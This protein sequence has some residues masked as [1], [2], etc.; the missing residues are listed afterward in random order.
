MNLKIDSLV[1]KI[2]FGYLILNA[3]LLVAVTLTIININEVEET[4]DEL[5]NVRHPTSTAEVEMVNGINHSVACLRGW[6]LLEKP[7]FKEELDEIWENEIRAPLNTLITLSDSWKLERNRKQLNQLITLVDKLELYQE[8][9]INLEIEEKKNVAQIIEDRILPIINKIRTL[10]EQLT[11]DHEKITSEVMNAVS[12]QIDFLSFTERILLISGLVIGLF[13]AFYITRSSTKPIHNAVEV[14]ENIAKGKIDTEVNVSG[15]KEVNQLGAALRSLRQSLLINKRETEEH[16]WLSDGENKLNEAI[17]GDQSTH[18]LADAFMK[19][20]ARYLNANIG[21]V[22]IIDQN[23]KELI[24]NASFAL[25]VDENLKRIKIGE[26]IIGHVAKE[27]NI[28]YLNELDEKDIRLESS[29]VKSTPKNIAVIPFMFEDQIL[30]VF[31]IG[32]KQEFKPIEREFITICQET[33]GIAM[34]SAIAKEEINLLYE[35]TKEKT[36]QLEN[37]K[38]EI[39][40]Q[41]EGLNNVALVSITDPNGD[42]TY[43]NDRFLEV[44]KF[45]REE[46]IGKNHRILKSGKQSDNLF[47]GMWKAISMGRVWNGEI[48]NKAKDGSYYWVDTTIIPILNLDNEV[49]KYLSV[50]FEITKIKEQQE[51]LKVLNEE[52]EEQSQSL[53]EQQEELQASNEELEE[54]SQNLKQQQE[55]LEAS[56]EELE[57]QAQV[58]E[59]KN[60]DLEAARTAIELKAEQLEVSSKYKSEFLANM[61]HELRTPLNSL[62]I[63]SKDLTDNKNGNLDEEQIESASIINK[64]GND[65][66]ELINEILDLSKVEAGKM[67]LN[68]SDIGIKDIAENINRNFKK[69]AEEK[70]IGWE[71]EIDETIPKTFRSDQQRLEQII[72]NLVSNAIKFTEEGKV[73]VLFNRKG[74]DQLSICV[75]DT[76]IGIPEDKLDAIFEAFQQADGSTSRKFGGT[77][78]GL[79]IS[80]E[81]TKLLGGTIIVES[82]Y[83]KGSAFT[84]TIP[85]SPEENDN[86]PKP[87]K[88]VAAKAERKSKI[89]NEID[90]DSE[91]INYPTI[92]D[93]REEVNPNDRVILIIEDDLNFSKIVAQQATKKDFK[94]ITAA[95]GE[96]GLMLAQ[97]YTPDAIILDIDLPGIDG[98]TVLQELKNDPD[99]RHIP[100]HIISGKDKN[101]ETIR[102]GAIEF[103]NKPV[104]KKELD[105]AF[106]NIQEFI[107]RQMKNLLIVEDNENMRNTIVKLIGNGDVKCHVASS[108][109]EALQKLKE[110]HVDCIVLDLGLPDMSGQEMLKQ[111][112][113]QSEKNKKIPPVIIYTGKELTKEED[114]ELQQ[115]AETIIVKGVKSEERLLDE[116]ALFLHRTVKNLPEN[117]QKMITELYDKETLFQHKTVLVV[118]D[119]MRN[120]FAL[121]KVLQ[122]KGMEVIKADNGIT[123]LKAL[124]ENDNIDIVL[125]DIMMPKMDGYTC[126]KEIRAQQQYINLPI[127][128]ITAKAMKEDKQKCIDAG[129]NDY[130]PKPVDIERLFSL[131]RIWIKK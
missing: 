80:R 61:S 65:L 115:F 15:F 85:L 106:E 98:Y 92:E 75:E 66:L 96:D 52:L 7:K 79:S 18:A 32:K 120:V 19:F 129:A 43:V 84:L 1:K 111:L 38:K 30:G 117:K 82:E 25:Q 36:Y 4:T 118:D 89:V 81:L 42:I 21:A 116:T 127:I 97:K 17:S 53:R 101:P 55:E 102:T 56:N 37:T 131:M 124:E 112:N 39:E 54:Q 107:N 93:Q 57:E 71:V 104:S 47:V 51:H 3:I 44:S 8:Q 28:F 31:E 87:E 16:K 62:L 76:G 68:I 9:V 35:E 125:M 6:V 130:I 70:G 64:C 121:S 29:V 69:V 94:F 50:R 27:K 77:G 26:G 99:L 109:K 95:T 83:E 126:M 59:E 72:K 58:I 113:K 33:I 123:A 110:I 24:I 34:H 108:A 14:A 73:S 88:V 78:L 90:Q 41:L 67:N 86:T 48:V 46:L 49:E 12:Q 5:T 45:P 119:D 103:L 11:V 114:N 13:L 91:Y 20:I 105:Q 74:E 122:E 100:V 40:Q 128:A 60:K 22:Y 23:N 10:I 63:L 2:G